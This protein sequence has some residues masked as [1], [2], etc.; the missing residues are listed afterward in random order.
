MLNGPV[1]SKEKGEEMKKSK[2]SKLA[3][4]ALCVT[5][6]VV[7]IVLTNFHSITSEDSTADPISK[8]MRLQQEKISLISELKGSTP[9]P[10]LYI[11]A[12]MLVSFQDASYK[13]AIEEAAGNYVEC[14]ALVWY[15]E[16]ND[17]KVKEA[18]FEE[19]LDEL[20]EKVKATDDF[21]KL[22][23]ACMEAGLSVDDLYRKNKEYYRDD[24]VIEK[25]YEQWVKSYSNDKGLT[26]ESEM[27]SADEAWDKF[28]ISAVETYKTTDDYKA[29]MPAIEASK[30]AYLR[31]AGAD[32]EKLKK[33][34]IFTSRSGGAKPT[35]R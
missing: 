15:A 34:D 31:G 22:N 18:E 23:A 13:D 8:S 21:P 14:K 6:I 20:I 16:H 3:G 7:G 32:A 27:P 35:R 1:S 24:F 4:A 26:L 5:V 33:Y 9:Y 2:W 29:L 28:I 17:I 10:Q 25:L 12:Q 30:T 19:H 11:N